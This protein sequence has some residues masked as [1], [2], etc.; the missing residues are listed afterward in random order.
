MVIHYREDKTPQENGK[1][2][3]FTSRYMQERDIFKKW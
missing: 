2:V 3:H 1:I